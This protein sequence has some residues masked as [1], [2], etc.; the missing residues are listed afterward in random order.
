MY[1]WRQR[2]RRDRGKFLLDGVDGWG[3]PKEDK[4]NMA[5][6]DI[7]QYHEE[8]KHVKFFRDNIRIKMHQYLN[9]QEGKDEIESLANVLKTAKFE[10]DSKKS[11][12]SIFR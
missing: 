6:D 5:D 9:T 1:I 3:P 10:I 2:T 7:L 12:Q 4:S 8:A 11:I